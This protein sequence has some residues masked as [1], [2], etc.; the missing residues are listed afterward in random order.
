[1]PSRKSRTQDKIPERWHWPLPHDL[2]KALA[3]QTPFTQETLQKVE[4]PALLF[5]RFIPYP[6]NP[7]SQWSWENKK[8]L[9]QSVWR[10][11]TERLN[12]I[13]SGSLKDISNEISS[14]LTMVRKGLEKQGYKFYEPLQAKVMWRLVV[15]LGLPNPLE[16]GF[17]LHHIYGIPF[18]PG[19]AIKGVTRAFRLQTIAEELGVPRLSV[20]DIEEWEN[21]T[22]SPTPW[23]L[24]D[25]LLTSSVPK[26]SDTQGRKE[27]LNKQIESRFNNLKSTLKKGKE[28]LGAPQYLIQNPKVLEIDIG[29]LKENYIYPFSRAFGSQQ[30]KGEIVFFDA[31]PTS[32]TVNGK[33]ILELDVMNP[34]YGEYYGSKGATPPADWLSPVPVLFLVVRCGAIFQITLA[35]RPSPYSS[36]DLLD[37]VASWTKA[38]LKELGIGAKTRAGYGQMDTDLIPKGDKK[39]P[40]QPETKPAAVSS[41]A[42][43]IENWSPREMGLL[44]Q[45]VFQLAS[46]PPDERHPLA[47]KLKEKLEKSGYWGGKYKEK[48]WHRQ[49]EQML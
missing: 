45:I 6:H 47:Q 24:L 42:I 16:T 4:N 31:Y 3:E 17:I 39:L 22:K 34:H 46:M 9:K 38:A 7:P 35:Q 12:E 48:A 21:R 23:K 37:T 41:L 13:Y 11:M 27:E 15:G 28:F 26:P 25:E 1:M 20:W 36:D 49:L 32:L 8:N 29:E 30:A 18:L 5:Q 43:A 19:S 2:Q 40:K 44:P 33:G 10:I 14:R